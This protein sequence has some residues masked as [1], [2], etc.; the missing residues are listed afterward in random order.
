MSTVFQ[1]SLT[2]SEQQILNEWR[3]L[4]QQ[5][6][7]SPMLL[8]AYKFWRQWA[9]TVEDGQLPS[10]LAELAEIKRLLRSGVIVTSDED[11]QGEQVAWDELVNDL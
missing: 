3:A 1:I 6:K 7:L 8:E 10:L 5:R 2:K 4:Q 9:H 11:E